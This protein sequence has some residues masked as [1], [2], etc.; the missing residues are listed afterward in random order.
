[1][2]SSLVTSLVLPVLDAIVSAYLIHSVLKNCFFVQP[3]FKSYWPQKN[4][5]KNKT[6]KEEE[7]SERWPSVSLWW[8]TVCQVM[9][10]ILVVNMQTFLQK[11]G[12]F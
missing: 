3:R 4:K 9:S 1:M 7:D 11:Q 8:P 5:N 12:N 6:K 10:A 2:K